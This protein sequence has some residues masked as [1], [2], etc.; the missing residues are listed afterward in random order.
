[1]NVKGPDGRRMQFTYNAK[2]VSICY[3][4]SKMIVKDVKTDVDRLK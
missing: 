2:V 3:G 4:M 1:M